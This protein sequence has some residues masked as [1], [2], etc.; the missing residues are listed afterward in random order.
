MPKMKKIA[1]M[2]THSY[3]DESSS[4][5]YVPMV[6][7]QIKFLTDAMAKLDIELLPI[8][9]EDLG[10]DWAQF[11]LVLPL[12]AWDYPSFPERFLSAL[13]EVIAAGTSLLNPIKILKEN[14]QKSYLT[15]L[16]EMGAKVPP[17]L[18][19]DMENAQAVYGAFDKFNCEE[20]IIKPI[21]GAGAWRQARLKKGDELP[22]R[23]DLPPNIA[24]V[25]PFIPSVATNGELSML[26]MGGELSHALMKT[27]K[28]GDYRTQPKY[29]AKEVNTNPPQE[30]L[31]AAKSILEKYDPDGELLY[32]RI[33]MV[34]YNNDWLLMEMELIEPY[35]YGP[36]DGHDGQLSAQ[37]FAAAIAKRLG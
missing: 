21:V 5:I 28:A 17:T 9:W 31:N 37:N 4:N 1:I 11:D 25:Q 35:L 3:Y 15:R 24:L 12:M 13:D 29:G 22:K 34:E 30:A 26:F 19:Y 27:P 32:A 2:V 7:E 10:N 6:R 18:E 20:I 14:M 33:D 23:E 36:F 8:Y 16:Y